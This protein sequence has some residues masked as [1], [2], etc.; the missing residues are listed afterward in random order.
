MNS[1]YAKY[2]GQPIEKIETTMD[3]DSFFEAEEAKAFG[4][5][6]EVYE[7]RP[8]PSEDAAAAN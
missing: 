6:D 2:T 8:M 4:I 1:L 5:V 3:R 7:K